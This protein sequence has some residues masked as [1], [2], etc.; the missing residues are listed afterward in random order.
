MSRHIRAW[1][2]YDA[3][4]VSLETGLACQDKSKAVQS[5]AGDADINQIVKRF[6]QTGEMPAGFRLPVQE[7]FVDILDFHSAQNAIAE[8]RSRFMLLPA[9]VRAR[10]DNDPGEFCDF[11]V[12]PANLPE[13]VKL[14]LAREPD[15][16]TGEVPGKGGAPIVAPG[17]S[18]EPGLPA[19]P[20]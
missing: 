12:D 8:A 7:D 10:F 17:S 13:L 19:K 9:A 3:D 14:G 4:K 20:A 15:P 2:N 16:V 6:T 5:Q 1:L 18:G 11:C